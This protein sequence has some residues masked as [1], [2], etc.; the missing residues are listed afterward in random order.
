MAIITLTTD[1]GRRDHYVGVMK[2][3]IRKFNPAAQIVDLTHE[4]PPQGVTQAAFVLYSTFRYF[5]EGTVHLAVVDPGVGSSREIL[6]VRAHRQFFIG[7]DNGL[8]SYI[9]D[10]ADSFEARYVKNKGL[11]LP[12]ISSTFQGRDIMAPAAARLSLGF[13][14]KKIGPLAEKIVRLTPIA[15]VIE[16]DSIRGRVIYVDYFGNLI[17]N[18]P[19]LAL[20]GFQTTV[21][22]GPLTIAGLSSSYNA[23][24]PGNYLAIAGSSGFMEIAR[25]MGRAESPPDLGLNTEIIIKKSKI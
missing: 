7:P 13:K 25:S 18:I 4:V 5:Q 6:V 19:S 14:F 24:E 23:V 16:D 9:L 17:T 21:I 22:A 11:F 10:E 2:G 12:A 3:V 20:T 8:F 15:P 1:F